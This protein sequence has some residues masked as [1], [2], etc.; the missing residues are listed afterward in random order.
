MAVKQV[1][2]TAYCP[3]PA[4]Q[5][6]AGVRD[7]CAPWHPLVADMAAVKTPS[8][9]VQREF[10]VTGEDT[11]YVERLTWFS[12]SARSM[13]YRH[14]Q[15]IEGID[16]YDGRLTVSETDPHTGGCH[17]T[18]SAQVSGPAARAAEVAEATQGIFDLGVEAIAAK[19][20]TPPMAPTRPAPAQEH[21]VQTRSIDS[22]PRLALSTMGQ[23]TLVL[24]L[25][26]IGGN[27]SNWQA[28]LAAVAPFATAAALDL[29]GYGDSSL[30][31]GQSTIDGYCDDILRVMDVLG[32]ERLVLCGLSY[33][34]WIATSFAMRHPDRLIGLLVAGGCTGMS[35]A[36]PEERDSFRVSREVPLNEGQTPA[37]FAPAVVEVLAGPETPAS[38]RA[39]LLDSMAA[40]PAATYADALRCFTNPLERFDFSRLTC[41]VLLMTGSYDRLAPPSEIRQVAERMYDSAAEPDVRFEEVS[42]AGHVC[43][44]DQPDRFNA[45]LLEFLGRVLP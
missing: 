9:G 21:P 1:R 30:G 8:G 28:Q 27:R 45:T 40:I 17:V 41:P 6:W 13:A 15:G 16:R 32:A 38:A 23:G 42:G 2:A 22:L 18:M 33:G 29:R 35:E 25:H 7:F 20:Q 26:G 43:N 3:A 39:A 10:H 5:V 36:G 19:T 4:D 34:A 44:L 37:D 24:F 31:A 11:L 14:M 12:D